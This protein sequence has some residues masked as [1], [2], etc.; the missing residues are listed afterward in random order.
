MGRDLG[1][2]EKIW[3]GSL[4]GVQI[5]FDAAPALALPPPPPRPAL[6]ASRASADIPPLRHARRGH[7]GAA[8]ADLAEQQGCV[9]GAQ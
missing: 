9:W 3:V 6:P 7:G 1:T 4:V 2:V 8:T 5:E